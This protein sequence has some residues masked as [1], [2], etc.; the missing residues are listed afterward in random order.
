M[1]KEE[2]TEDTPIKFEV[3]PS[4]IR[5]DIVKEFT[6]KFDELKEALVPP[7]KLES[8]TEELEENVETDYRA[9]LVENIKKHPK[10]GNDG[11]KWTGPDDN[12]EAKVLVGEAKV[13]D[14]K[15]QES[16]TCVTAT[17]A[18]PEIWA[19]EVERLS[20]YPN[21][22]FWGA[23]YVNWKKDVLGRPGDTVNVITVAPVVCETWDC[24]EPS[25]DA[26]TISKVPITLRDEVCAYCI[27]K[28]DLED[29]VPDTVNA[30]N[31]GLGSCLSVCIDNHFLKQLQIGSNAGTYT[32]TAG[33][34]GSLIARAMGSMQAGTYEP[35]VLIMHPVVYKGLMQDSQFTNAATFGNRSVIAKGEIDSY[36]GVD[37]VERPKGT[38]CVGNC[39][40][41]TYRSVLLA[42]GAV[43]GAIKRNITLETEYVA[44]LQRKYILAS[45]RYGGTVVHTNGVFWIVTVQT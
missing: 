1:T 14:K 36:L 10:R 8:E 37:M 13:T 9:I 28:Q 16:L 5:D 12:E 30:L 15:L 7:E 24:A 33:M 2:E 23:P 25:N 29:V 20:V 27:C 18:I 4:K 41:G 40:S 43:A 39:T 32:H 31:E 17:N 34:T 38:L 3:D 45:V 42:K 21:S 35:A 26:A 44:R 11:W 22:A 19:A 6:K